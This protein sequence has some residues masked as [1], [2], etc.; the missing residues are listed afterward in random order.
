MEYDKDF[1]FKKL[2]PRELNRIKETKQKITIGDPLP[3]SFDVS[4]TGTYFLDLAG[5]MVL[6][7]PKK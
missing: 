6:V 4:I 7:E 2:K 5:N 1:I 3:P